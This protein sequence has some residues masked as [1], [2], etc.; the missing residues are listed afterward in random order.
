M[1][2]ECGDYLYLTNFPKICNLAIMIYINCFTFD[3]I[4]PTKLIYGLNPCERYMR[5]SSFHL[6]NCDFN[7]VLDPPIFIRTIYS[8]K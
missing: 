8:F 5:I 3:K 4:F 2:I 7:K 6:C 1:F